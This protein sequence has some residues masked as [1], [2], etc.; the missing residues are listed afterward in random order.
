MEQKKKKKG[1]ERKV[2]FI[3]KKINA[4]EHESAIWIQFWIKSIDELKMLRSWFIIIQER[5]GETKPY[6]TSMQ[7]RECRLNTEKSWNKFTENVSQLLMPIISFSMC[8]ITNHI[9]SYQKHHIWTIV[10]QRFNH[11][12]LKHWMLKN[13]Q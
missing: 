3:K 11:W 5:G 1:N 10:K 9:I 2:Y 13:Y 6:T 12:I 4:C 8:S 7:L